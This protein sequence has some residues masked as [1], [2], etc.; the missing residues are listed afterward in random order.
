MTHL[1]SIFA[2]H[3]IPAQLLTDNEPQYSS[4]EFKDFTESY[5]IEHLTSSLHYPEANGS[6][7]RMLQTV[8]N[9]LI[10]C[11]EEEGDLSLALLSY[12]ATPIDH[13]VTGR[14]TSA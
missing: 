4:K 1:K 6:S 5:G 2:E 8:K 14:A 9:I 13:K 11:G 12:R 10:K 3:D 7:E